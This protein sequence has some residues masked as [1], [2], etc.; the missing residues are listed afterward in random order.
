M[1]S[2]ATWMELKAIILSKLN[3]EQ[4]QQQQKQIPHVLA[5]KWELKLAHVDINKAKRKTWKTA[6]RGRE[7][8]GGERGWVEKLLGTISLPG[9]NI[10]M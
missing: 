8:E 7:G 4:Q 6:G 1:S 9:Y 3:Q 2:A 5:Y 10:L